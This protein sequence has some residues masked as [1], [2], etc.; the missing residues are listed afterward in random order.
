MRGNAACQ[1]FVLDKCYTKQ[2]LTNVT[3]AKGRK[4][5]KFFCLASQQEHLLF[6]HFAQSGAHTLYSVFWPNIQAAL[7]L[8]ESGRISISLGV[9]IRAAYTGNRELIICSRL[10]IRWSADSGVHAAEGRQ[11]RDYCSAQKKEVVSVLQSQVLQRHSPLFRTAPAP[12][13]WQTDR[14]SE[15]AM[16]TRR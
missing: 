9:V 4:T 14:A 1:L 15:N 16:A 7:T 10:V 2:E 11:R 5:L 3:I 8:L 12:A 13:R 6:P